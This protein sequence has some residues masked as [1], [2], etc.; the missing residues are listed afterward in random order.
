MN[1]IRNSIPHQLY[2]LGR[3]DNQCINNTNV[4]K[5]ARGVVFGIILAALFTVL[6]SFLTLAML[7]PIV[8]YLA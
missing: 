2:T 7:E 3:S 8:S 5:Y 6:G 1:I 4:C